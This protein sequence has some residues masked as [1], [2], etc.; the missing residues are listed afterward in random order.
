MGTSFPIPTW[1][2]VEAA[3]AAFKQR[4]SRDVM[5]RATVELVDRA[6]QGDSTLSVAESLAV[7]LITWNVSYYRFHGRFSEQHY[8]NLES[9]LERHDQ[10]L[11]SFAE[12]D[13]LTFES[14]DEPAIAVVFEE[15]EQA[16]GVVGAAK[17]LHVL[18]RRFFPLWDR[19]IAVAYGLRPGPRGTNALRYIRF[20]TIVR[21]QVRSIHEDGASDVPNLLKL[22]DEYNYARFTWRWI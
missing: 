20:M 10:T 18:A 21:R 12:R 2:E 8:R 6:R 15:L 13:I 1:K 9:L 22:L 19:A 11:R 14:A 16:S 7:L 3:R 4:E 5:Y 17:V